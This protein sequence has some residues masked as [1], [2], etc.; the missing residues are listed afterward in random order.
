[1]GPNATPDTALHPLREALATF[2][3][4]VPGMLGAAVVPEVL[5]GRHVEAAIIAALLMSASLD[6]DRR[7]QPERVM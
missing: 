5:L 1:V 6:L 3:A 4:P 2:W 7:V